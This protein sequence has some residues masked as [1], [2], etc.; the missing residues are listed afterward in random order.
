ML[1]MSTKTEWLAFFLLAAFYITFLKVFRKAESKPIFIEDL[2]YVSFTLETLLIWIVNLKS[3]D[4][5]ANLTNLE[6]W[7]STHLPEIWIN[8]AEIETKFSDF[9]ANAHLLTSVKSDCKRRKSNSY[10]R[11]V[12][13]YRSMYRTE[14]KATRKI[15]SLI[16]TNGH[17]L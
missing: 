7:R 14:F 5:D 11:E 1:Q 2:L 8:E 10:L 13:L 16:I 17:K 3:R 4:H 12:N 6:V 15:P 9:L